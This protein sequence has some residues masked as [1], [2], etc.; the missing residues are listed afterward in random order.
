MLLF[1]STH[2]LKFIG[3]LLDGSEQILLAK[4]L[5]NDRVSSRN[6]LGRNASFITRRIALAPMEFDFL[7]VRH[8]TKLHC[9]EFCCSSSDM[10][11]HKTMRELVWCYVKYLASLNFRKQCYMDILSKATNKAHFKCLWQGCCP[12][13]NNLWIYSY[14]SWSGALGEGHDV[15]LSSK[16][17][18][19]ACV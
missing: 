10:F 4:R 17:S 8:T 14:V 7:K 19:G 16:V 15:F 2:K 3:Y 11:W 5:G 9:H 13:Y 18:R 12:Y 6:S 1:L